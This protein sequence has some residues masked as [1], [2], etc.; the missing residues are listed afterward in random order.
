MSRLMLCAV[1]LAVGWPSLNSGGSSAISAQGALPDVLKQSIAYYSTLESYSDT[2][3]VKVESSGTVETSRFST[4]FRRA[5][6]DLQLVFDPI[7]SVTVASGHSISFANHRTVIWMVRGEMQKWEQVGQT[8]EAV[9]PD[10]GGQVRALHH[11]GHRTRGVSM[12]IPSLLYSK[13]NLPSTILQIEEAEPGGTESIDGRRCHKVVGHAAAYYPSG[14][15]TGVRPV[16]VWIDAE[17][18]LVRR[19]FE[20]TPKAYGAGAYLRVTV[21]FKP[22]ANPTLDDTKFHFTVPAS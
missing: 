6:R 11:A 14:Q 15:R 20:D 17:S 12:L 10:G 21:D 4:H 18:Q 9:N 13:A 2:G 5:T 22:Q 1:V 3:T 8:H 19:V 16:T 7:S